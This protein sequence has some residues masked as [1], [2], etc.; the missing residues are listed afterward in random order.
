[1]S[2]FQSRLLFWLVML[3]LLVMIG[4]GIL[5]GQI[6]KGFYTNTYNERLEKEANIVVRLVEQKGVTGTNI[7]VQ[8]Q[9]VANSLNTRVTI[10]D[11]EGKIQLDS[12][13]IFE[14]NSNELIE[15]Y[16]E[17]IVEEELRE[18]PLHIVGNEKDR[19]YYVVPMKDNALFSKGY[20]LLSQPVDSFKDIYKQIWAVLITCIGLAFIVMLILGSR[21]TRYYMKP[22][23][24]ATIVATELAKGNFKARTYEN[25]AKETSMLSQSI[26]VLA[27]N[28]EEMVKAQEIQQS[29]L[30]TLIESMGSGLI[31][32]DSRGYINLINRSYKDIFNVDSGEYLFRPYNEVIDHQEV[33]LLIE[34][35]FMTEIKVRRHLQLNFGI[36]R[37][38]FEVYGSPIISANDEWKGILLVFHDISGLKKLEQIRQDFVANVSHELKTPITSI[39]GFS[40]TLLD[41]AMKDEGLLEN[42]LGIILKES[43]R[44]QSLIQDLLDLS[45]IEQ[46]GYSINW[47]RVELRELLE[48]IILLLNGK[49]EERKVKLELQSNEE[50]FLEGDLY[51]LKQIFINL[52]NNAIAYT[53]SEGTVTVSIKELKNKI[54]VKVK[55]T[56]IGIAK[57]ELPRIFERFYRIDK[58]R[59]RNSGGTGLGL[60]IVKHLVDVHNGSI[61]VESEQGLGTTFTIEFHKKKHH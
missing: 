25:H 47:Q 32:I 54:Q 58:A 59:S 18:K 53:P 51:R 55:D 37:K 8:I 43:D 24:S 33:I 2:R 13:G 30:T 44:L 28:L 15:K 61:S 23:E 31:L 40:E 49:A 1:M 16:K 34:E 50:C 12:E 35:I 39:K 60:A 27:R 57:E 36:I 48:E 7:N 29:R 26:N 17:R 38:H 20:L 42:F 21:I 6:F 4:M 52:I 22:I 19:F 56:G 9:E 14:D 10:V 41:G 5:I 46:P 45:K 3:T 11:L